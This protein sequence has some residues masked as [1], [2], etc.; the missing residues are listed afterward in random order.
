MR[1]IKIGILVVAAC[2]CGCDV[3]G[4]PDP[5]KN[6]LTGSDRDEHGCIPS[7]GYNWCERTRQCERP[8]ELAKD[9]G[10]DNTPERFEAY[11]EE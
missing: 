1:K 4:G 2:L 8:W 6:G 10:F 11:C 3:E 9:K 5:N 7:A